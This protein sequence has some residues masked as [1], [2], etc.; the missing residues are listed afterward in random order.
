[1]SSVAELLASASQHYQAGRC[2]LAI[3][4]LRTALRLNPN[5]PEAHNNLGTALAQAGRL[6]EAASS[7]QEAVRLK[8]DYADAH[9][10]LA[11]VL[12]EQG[13]L[14]R[15]VEH[16]RQA[17]RLRPDYVAAHQ[18]LALALRA[19]E[20][21]AETG[22]GLPET[23]GPGSMPKAHSPA[24]RC[25]LYGSKKRPAGIGEVWSVRRRALAAC[26]QE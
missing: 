6:E 5:I 20:R 21:Q 14:A 1:M 4:C 3:D 11:N 25:F 8:P 2:E 16:L 23:R 18:N 19:E 13:H 17:I 7:F 26:D 15:A 22:A 12:R 10:N 24:R 9:N